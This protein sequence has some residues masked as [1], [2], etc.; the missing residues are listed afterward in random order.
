[1]EVYRNRSLKEYS[2]FKIGGDA[3]YLIEVK[4]Q[5]EAVQAI[6]F[7]NQHNLKWAVVGKG[8]NTLFSDQ[9][10]RG[11]V[12][13]NLITHFVQNENIFTVGAG[14]S[15]AY[16]GIKTASLGYSGLEFASG[17]P[18]SVGG[19]VYMNAGACGSE[20]KDCLNQVVFCDEAGQIQTLVKEVLNFSYR[21][22]DFQKKKGM[23][24]EA[25]FSLQKNEQAKTIQQ[26]LLNHR[27]KTQPYQDPSIGCFFKNPSQA[28][29]AGFLIDQCGL[30]GMR[31]GGAQV[32]TL[33]ANFIV[34]KDHA[35]ASDVLELKKL[36]KA[37]VL[38]KTGYLLEE[39]VYVW[40]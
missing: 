1:M 27:I 14:F 19:A 9:G 32:S 25:T 36:I 21:K 33:H 6:S 18:G 31:V 28:V 24:I 10:F 2:T 23:I 26:Q 37:L 30:K 35:S 40:D 38:E 16:L 4:T 12:I 17:I 8:S 5:E 13:V 3:D 29:K 11:V 7:A 34:N 20:T 39:E 22:S 15:F